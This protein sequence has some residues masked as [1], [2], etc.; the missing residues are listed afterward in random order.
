M[1]QVLAV[2][3]VWGVD[4]NSDVR[5]AVARGESYVHEGG[6]ISSCTDAHAILPV[7]TNTVILTTDENRFLH[8]CLSGFLGVFTRARCTRAQGASVV[9]CNADTYAYRI[10]TAHTFGDGAAQAP[11]S[12]LLL[13]Q[14]LNVGY[15]QQTSLLHLCLSTRVLKDVL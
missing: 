4:H 12:I 2:V 6:P 7:A 15:I 3:R 13:R 9:K 8:R 5:V 11:A 10:T 14:P 1:E